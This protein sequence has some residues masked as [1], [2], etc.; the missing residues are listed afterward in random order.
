MRCSRSSR[1][2]LPGLSLERWTRL[3][4]NICTGELVKEVSFMR[5]GTLGYHANGIFVVSDMLLHPRLRP[6]SLA[7]FHVVFGQPLQIPVTDNGFVV[8]MVEE[9]PRPKRPV[10]Y[11]SIRP[12]NLE[13]IKK[14]SLRSKD[15]NRF[16]TLLGK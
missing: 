4:F 11:T 3:Q 10:A 7:E 12:S 9:P 15:Q 5:D 6:Q 8:A 1:V 16:G 2:S 14:S 13:Y